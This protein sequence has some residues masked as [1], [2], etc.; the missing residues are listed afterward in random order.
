MKLDID[1]VA[2]GGGSLFPVQLG[3]VDVLQEDPRFEIRRAAGTSAGSILAGGLAFGL[4]VE[5]ALDLC[6]RV[7]RN[8]VL[9][10]PPSW[11]MALR[12]YRFYGLHSFDPLR[13]ELG[14]HLG[15]AMRLSS[16]EDWGAHVFSLK[17]RGPIFVRASTHP[18]V[19]PAELIA[20]S[21]AIP[22]MVNTRTIGGMDGRFWDGGIVANFPLDCWDDKPNRL[23]VG[24]R[25]LGPP[26]SEPVDS[27]F[28]AARATAEGLLWASN[29]AHGSCKSRSSVIEVEIHGNALDFS[30]SEREV[31]RRYDAG[32]VG[33]NRWLRSPETRNLLKRQHHF[34][35]DP[36]DDESEVTTKCLV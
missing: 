8:N 34:A 2:A 25:A 6:V 22:W 16:F 1:I 10:D 11:W 28:D 12:L 21:C 31:I 15:D 4:T 7:L 36:D 3:V 27:V 24:I 14:R 17:E 33:A 13:K 29:N 23:T 5:K 32:R 18:L 20:A 30:L 26:S 19:N 9:M 35:D